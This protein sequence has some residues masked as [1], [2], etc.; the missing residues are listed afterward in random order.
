MPIVETQVRI[1]APIETVYGIA[2]DNESF[3]EFMADVQSVN[4]IEKSSSKVVS[5]WVGIVSAFGLKIRW[6]Q[7]DIWDD[8]SKTCHF[9]MLK[10][11]YDKLEGVWSFQ[12]EGS[13]TIFKSVVDYEYKVPGIGALVYKVIHSLVVKNLDDTLNAIKIRAEQQAKK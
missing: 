12:E 5:D 2:Q 10:G 6:T 1:Q 11:D 9:K 13:D 8:A 7:E 3:P 4:V